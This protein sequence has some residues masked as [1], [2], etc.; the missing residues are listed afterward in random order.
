MRTRRSSLA[1]LTLWL[2]A[3]GSLA[4]TVY[5]CGPQGRTYSQTP[6]ADG[7][8]LAISDARTET[9]RLRALALANEQSALLQRLQAERRQREALARE[10]AGRE[11][12]GV[13]PLAPPPTA[14]V[15]RPAGVA[16]HR[17]E[18]ANTARLTNAPQG[19]RGGPSDA[20]T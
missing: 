2:C 11:P 17:A 9:Q 14:G 3:T 1:A 10:V 18:P 6:C 19:R 5:R 20:G 15:A 8:A 16:G 7:V 4:E 13:K 12:A